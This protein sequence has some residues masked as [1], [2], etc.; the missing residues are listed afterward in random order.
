MEELE[1]SSPTECNTHNTEEGGW[2][3]MVEDQD[4]NDVF[5]QDIS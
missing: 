3:Y 1:D 4:D 5:V 2:D